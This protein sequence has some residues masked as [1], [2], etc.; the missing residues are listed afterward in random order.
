MGGAQGVSGLE[1]WLVNTVD[2]VSRLA[3]GT[4]QFGLNYGVANQSGQVSADEV[5]Q[6][7][8]AA[9]QAGVMTL[10][11]ATAYGESERVLGLQNLRG[12]SIIT[13]LPEMPADCSSVA[14]WVESQLHAS[15][16]RLGLSAID[17][18]LLHRPGQ[19]LEPHGQE[20]YRAL[21]AQREQGLVSRIGISV[22]GPEELEAL[23]RSYHFDLVQ[24]P[25]NVLDKRLLLSGWLE[26]LKRGGT[27]LHVRSVFM[28]GLLLMSS[29]QRPAKFARW[30]SQW[31]MWEQWLADTRQ[32]PLEACLRHALSMAQIERVVIGVDSASQWQE[33][34]RASAGNCPPIP[35]EL[36]CSDIELLNPSLWS[37]L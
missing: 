37:R 11:T 25:F 2:R 4:A 14:G 33:I 32:S 5:G 19:L 23:C 21:Q 1:C 30:A 26:R 18:L 36:G 7:L 13:K 10:D 28:Q 8:E 24:A 31:S 3:L 16:E 15:L 29:E 12:F 22:Y 35:S 34:L 6:I 9:R 20:L 27:D 17:G